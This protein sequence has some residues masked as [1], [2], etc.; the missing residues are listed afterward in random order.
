MG[1][2]ILER[3]HLN[4]CGCLP[5]LRI[6]CQTQLTAYPIW[7][8]PYPAVEYPISS[9]GIRHIPHWNT[10]YQPFSHSGIPHIPHWNTKY[11]DIE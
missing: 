5:I 8:T 4:S 1:Y 9:D 2:L 7:N 6:Q 11:L 10:P 3:F